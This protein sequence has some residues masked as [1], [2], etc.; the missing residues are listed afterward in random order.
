[1][2]RYIKLVLTYPVCVL[3][4]LLAVTIILALG[5]PRLEFDSSADVMM[6]RHDEQYLYYQK[7]KDIYGNIGTFV[8]MNVTSDNIWTP[9][10]FVE[11]NNL[12]LVLRKVLHLVLLGF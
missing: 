12:Y 6:P 9:G 2:V 8:I 1:M 4:T 10:F 3:I 5:I 7:V 11:M